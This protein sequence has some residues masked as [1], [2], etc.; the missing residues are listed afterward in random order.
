MTGRVTSKA[1]PR[2]LKLTF[3]TAALPAG[4]VLGDKLRWTVLLDEG[5]QELHAGAE[6][7]PNPQDR[8]AERQ[9]QAVV[10]VLRN[11]RLAKTVRF[12]A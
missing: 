4:T 11:G 2:G 1:I 10:K 12:R 5:P 3:A 9:R 8:A 6:H 7:A